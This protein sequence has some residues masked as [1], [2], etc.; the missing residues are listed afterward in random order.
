LFHLTFDD[1]LKEMITTV[2]PLL[3]ELGIPATFFI[4]TGFIGNKEMFYRYKTSVL[5]ENLK[6]SS[7]TILKTTH[8]LLDRQGIDKG[9]LSYRLLKVNYKT[10]AVL[11]D[12]A[13]LIDTDFREYAAKHDIYLHEEDIKTL[14][15]QGFTIG[16]HSIDHPEFRLEEPEEQIRQTLGSVEYL[17]DHIGI[18]TA[19]FSFPFSDQDVSARFFDQILKPVGNVDLTFG[20]SGLKK[21]AIPCHLY[22]IPMETGLFSAEEIIKGEYLYFMMKAIAGKNKID[23]T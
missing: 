4:N 14:M 6:K 20:I 22:R 7:E 23:R 21:D 18:N 15:E 9:T 10:R 8:L 2:A 5:I 16:A 1:G 12:I 13:A 17:Q 19:Y 11:D 3:K